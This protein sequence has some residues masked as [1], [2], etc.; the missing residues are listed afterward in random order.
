MGG[1]GY[2]TTLVILAHTLHDHV[3]RC[4]RTKDVT[5]HL[6]TNDLHSAMKEWLY[7]SKEE[8]TREAAAHTWDETV[9]NV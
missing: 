5:Y 3:D 7:T 1:M 8:L 9:D 2:T 4:M 6:M